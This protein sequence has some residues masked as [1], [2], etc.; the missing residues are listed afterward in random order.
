M[1]GIRNQRQRVGPEARNHFNPREAECQRDCPGKD[2]LASIFRNMT[3]FGITHSV[4]MQVSGYCGFRFRLHYGVTL[5][6][7]GLY[8][9]QFGGVGEPGVVK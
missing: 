1:S 9:N 7:R 6:D 2:F 5:V 3:V 4:C 8:D